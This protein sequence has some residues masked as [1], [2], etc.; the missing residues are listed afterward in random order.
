MT[1][2]DFSSVFEVGVGLNLAF[3][4][5]EYASSYTNILAKYVYKLYEK[6]DSEFD[7]CKNIVNSSAVEDLRG[8]VVD[9][10]N[11]VAQ[12]EELKVK[13]RNCMETLEA[14]KAGLIADVDNKCHFRCFAFISL[15][16]SLYSLLALFLSGYQE[17]FWAVDLWNMF[18]VASVLFVCFYTL[19]VWVGWFK[20]YTTSLISGIVSFVF[21]L[22]LSFVLNLVLRHF[23]AMTDLVSKEWLMYTIPIST[24]MPYANFVMFVFIMSFRSKKLYKTAVDVVKELKPEWESMKQTVSDLGAVNRISSDLMRND[25]QRS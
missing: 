5:A 14:R 4:A 20:A 3:V 13:Y 12:V 9:G 1:L 2:G 15:Y 17:Y 25:F 24:F 22:L 6:I 7:F 18:T 10:R 19:F 11:T 21:V 16:L 8:N 23:G